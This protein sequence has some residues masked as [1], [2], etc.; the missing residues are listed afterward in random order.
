[1]RNSHAHN[2]R[3]R[4][5]MTL[6]E[7]VIAIGVG[8]VAITI[9]TAI[10]GVFIT[11]V[12]RTHRVALDALHAATSRALIREWIGGAVLTHR[13]VDSFRGVRSDRDALPLDRLTFVT[14]ANTPLA[15]GKTVTLA[16]AAD[17]EVDASG[18]I[19]TLTDAQPSASSQWVIVTGAKSLRLEYLTGSDS[20]PRWLPGWISGQALPL[21]VRL[22]VTTESQFAASVLSIPLIARLG[23]GP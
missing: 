22:N 1:M 15:F 14:H 9:A 5:G 2:R 19:A 21:A 8:A 3:P 23:R 18:L 10:L 4:P 11:R 17:A 13:D 6:I 16:I 7:V 12:N 20:V